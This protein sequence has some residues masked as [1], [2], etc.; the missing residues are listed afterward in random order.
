M[1]LLRAEKPWERGRP[2]RNERGARKK[3]SLPQLAKTC[4]V[5]LGKLTK[6]VARDKL[7][8]LPESIALRSRF[9]IFFTL[10]DFAPLLN[11]DGTSALPPIRGMNTIKSR[12]QKDLRTRDAQPW[13]PAAF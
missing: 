2:V 6:T 5:R 3:P 7:I 10:T 8:R 13:L 12:L 11:A 9:A 4:K 1:N